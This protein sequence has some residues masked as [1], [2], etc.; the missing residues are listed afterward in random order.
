MTTVTEKL[1]LTLD[2]AQHYGLPE[3]LITD[4]KYGAAKRVQAAAFEAEAEKLKTEAN[5]ILE[6]ALQTLAVFAE[7]WKTVEGLGTVKSVIV[8][9]R[10]FTR[11][12]NPGRASLDKDKMKTHLVSKGVAPGLVMAA[13]EAGT[14]V[15]KG[16]VSV[17][18]G[19]E[20]A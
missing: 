8:D 10:V 13:I 3:E 6:P 12:V 5:A 14:S 11:V 2:E 15:G 18:M 4:L 1:I 16:Y 9:G 20:G 7:G 17:S 19:K